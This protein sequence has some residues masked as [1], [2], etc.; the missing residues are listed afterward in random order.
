MLRWAK[1]V[2]LVLLLTLIPV[3]DLAQRGANERSGTG[4]IIRVQVRMPGGR[5]AS[6]GIMVL[7]EEQGGGV[8]AQAQTDS[9]G[10]CTFNPP[11]PAVYRV[12]VKQVG[13]SE[14]QAEAD[15]TTQK[16]AF[17]MMELK[18][19]PGHEPPPP[20]GGM[21]SVNVSDKA[22]KEFKQGE[23][24]LLKDQDIE[25]SIRHLKKA[26][27]ISKDFT[28][29]YVMLGFAYLA[30]KNPAQAKPVL[31][32]ALKLDPK[33]WMAHV[34]LGAAYNLEKRY[35]DAER[36]LQA[37]LALNDNAAVGHY[38]LA[39]TYWVTNR[40]QDAEPHA[41][42]AV[43]LAPDLAA[44]HV[45]LGNV[46]I[47]KQDFAGAKHEFEEYLRIE[48]NG[49]MAAASKDMIAKLNKASKTDKR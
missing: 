1:L 16:S 5:A 14:I 38:E 49:P 20:P 25:G 34:E 27:G 21:I 29:A 2:L 44:A 35:P 4:N 28:D 30:Q 45:L 10:K 41:A 37:G 39:K 32:K 7:L 31:E 33:S 13:Y 18:P 6:Q 46:M 36:E 40:W 12:T 24:R 26:I 8:V 43:E 9:L 3:S 11:N 19:L 22:V 48:P 47:R 42:K 23:T 17:L 15:L